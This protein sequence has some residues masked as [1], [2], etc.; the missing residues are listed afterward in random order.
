[1]KVLAGCEFSGI[2]RDAFKKRGHDAW[3]CDLLP[4]EKPGQHIQGDVLA[5]L[6]GLHLCPN[7]GGACESDHNSFQCHKC[8]RLWPL[9]FPHKFIRWDLMIA[10]PPCTY[11]T[12]A[13]NKWFNSEYKT[14]FPNRQ[15]QRDEAAAFFMTLA[16]API[17]KIAIENPIGVMSTRWHKPDQ[18]IQPYQ[19]GI[20]VR[21]STCL[22]LKGL[23]K[24]K[25][26]KIVSPELDYFPSGNCQSKWHTETGR[27]HDKLERRKARS[28]T[29][30]GIADAMAEQWGS[31]TPDQRDC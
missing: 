6:D 9:T 4:T 13:G 16:N 23:P 14:R 26:T 2:V 22:W 27:I 30:Q 18:I 10:H 5:Y 17:N 8:E 31:Y 29:F 7:C 19:F 20:P 12:V 24:L 25:P 28:R 11:L 21:K 1:M 3:G 15:S